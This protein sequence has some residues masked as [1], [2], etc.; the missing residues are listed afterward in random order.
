[1]EGQF[2][3]RFYRICFTVTVFTIILSSSPTG[4]VGMCE[5]TWTAHGDS[6]YLHVN[7][8]VGQVA[9]AVDCS[10]RGGYVV[11]IADSAENTFVQS[12]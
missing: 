12:L 1:M 9:A 5:P 7:I 6:C 3:P 2:V 4:A 8:A 10:S 11:A